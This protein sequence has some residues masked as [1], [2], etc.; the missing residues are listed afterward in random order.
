MAVIVGCWEEGVAKDENGKKWWGCGNRSSSCD[1]GW[2]VEWGVA[3]GG[4]GGGPCTEESM[5]DKKSKVEQGREGNRLCRWWT[6][7]L[8]NVRGY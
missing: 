8:V 4:G 1:E 7:G 6:A 3:K 2:T 5:D